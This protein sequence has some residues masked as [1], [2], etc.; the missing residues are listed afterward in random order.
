M[1]FLTRLL[2][3]AAK[4]REPMRDVA[5][6]AESLAM[7]AVHVLKTAAR[8]RSWL[9]GEPALA[10]GVAW[11]EYKDRRLDFLAQLNLADIAAAQ[12]MDWLPTTGSLSFFYD[13]KTQPSGLN[14][15]DR[16]AWRVVYQQDGPSVAAADPMRG[17]EFR[18]IRTYPPTERQEV[19]ALGLSDQ[20]CD[21]YCELE[22]VQTGIE[23]YHQVGGYPQLIQADGL[24]LDAQLASNGIPS[25]SEK[26]YQSERAQV[27][28]AGASDW[29]LLFQIAS[30]RNGDFMWG[31]CGNLY[32]MIR[33]SDARAVRFDNVWL[34]S[35]CF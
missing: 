4:P 9:T 35:Q 33:E 1:G 25:G 20:E 24:E 32:F 27:L 2:G 21:A 34:L 5:A 10:T 13:L 16:G 29:R 8:S 22:L 15:E 23:Y 28:A 3:G 7:P 11:P 12:P 30:E 19:E 14:P 26:S 17:V 18:P 6:L 31:D